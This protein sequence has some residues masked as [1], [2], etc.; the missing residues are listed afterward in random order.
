[1]KLLGK[2]GS[3]ALICLRKSI[4][5]WDDRIERERMKQT[6]KEAPVLAEHGGDRKS[7]AGIVIIPSALDTATGM[8]R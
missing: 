4:P 7:E 8:L 6:V 5:D 2:K 1:M 3:D